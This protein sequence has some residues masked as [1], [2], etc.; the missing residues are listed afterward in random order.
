MTAGGYAIGSSPGG[1][2]NLCLTNTSIVMK[3]EVRKKMH[4]ASTS[5]GPG[6]VRA[7]Q[8]LWNGTLRVQSTWGGQPEFRVLCSIS[9]LTFS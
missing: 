7:L 8:R 2:F 6:D 4:C 1:S 9:I 5:Q 3:D